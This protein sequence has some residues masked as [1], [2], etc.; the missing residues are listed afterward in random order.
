MEKAIL[1]ATGLG[2]GSCWLGGTFRRSRFAER[3]SA[4]SDEIVPAV[5]SLGYPAPS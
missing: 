4:R 3:I 5:A 1:Y 2:L